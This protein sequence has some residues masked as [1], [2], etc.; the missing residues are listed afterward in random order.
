MEF[1]VHQGQVEG[2][3]EAVAELQRL[4]MTAVA[5]DFE[6]EESEMHWHDFDSRVYVVEGYLRIE[7]PDGQACD[8]H[9][10]D[11]I[12]ADAGVVHREVTRG[13]RA[14]IGFA[15]DPTTLSRPINKPAS[16]L[17]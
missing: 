2:E 17:V 6:P 1:E 10:G 3:D 16:E 7:L 14:V 5:L 13:Y 4:G 15:V 8:L 9:A 11:M 12:E